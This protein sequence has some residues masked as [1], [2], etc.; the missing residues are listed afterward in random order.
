MTVAVAIPRVRYVGNGVAPAFAV[1]FPFQLEEDLRVTRFD[2]AGDGSELDLNI[3]FTV[4]TI[5][6]ASEVRLLGGPL[7]SGYVLVIERITEL[8]QPTDL[9][10]QAAGFL[11]A[12]EDAV[13]RLM[14]ILQEFDAGF[15][16]RNPD[17][18]RA[19]ILGLADVDGAGS[20]RAK[21]NRISGL[22]TPTG[23]ADAATRAWVESLLTSALQLSGSNIPR[24][25]HHAG[26]GATTQFAIPGASLAFADGYMVAVGGVLQ[27]PDTHYA[28]DLANSRLVFVTPPPLGVSIVI[29]SWGYEIPVLSQQAAPRYTIATK[30]VASSE[31]E[32]RPIRVKDPGA[33][34]IEQVCLLK[35]DGV[36]W[37][38]CT[39]A[40]APPF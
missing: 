31:W 4:V 14:M 24:R 25:W 30:P 6:G 22:G 37:V 19:L 28:I 39:R 33:P 38:W 29:R 11:Q 3:D 35:G 16:I 18:S 9:E 27:E 26:D 5:G 12:T 34:E 21:G 7:A 1:P 15:S 36:T 13:D 2:T 40:S 23:G 32:G 20:Y 17:L 10:N 8:K